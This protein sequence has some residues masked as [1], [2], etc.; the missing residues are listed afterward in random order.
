MSLRYSS[1]LV[2]CALT[3]LLGCS[4]TSENASPVKGRIL[5]NGNPWKQPQGTPPGD[6]GLRVEFHE[7]DAA[8]Q[9]VTAHSAVISP[10]DGSFNVPGKT[11][12]GLSSGKYR[13]SVHVGAYGTP[14]KLKGELGKEKSPLVLEVPTSGDVVIDIGKKTL[15]K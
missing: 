2:A 3:L 5:D 15:V 11:G 13:I 9:I 8:G 6:L 10:E 4:S 1:L 7:L 14:D 12:K